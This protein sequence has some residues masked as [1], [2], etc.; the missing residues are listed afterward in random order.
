MTA[1][2]PALSTTETIFLALLS[3]GWVALFVYWTMRW[4]QGR[5]RI[6]PP[7]GIMI[8]FAL[9]EMLA[10]LF[11]WYSFLARERRRDRLRKK[12]AEFIALADRLHARAKGRN[13]IGAI[14]AG[15]RSKPGKFGVTSDI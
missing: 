6:T 3:I 15:S 4:R 8:P 2:Q 10:T 11:T 14:S 13:Q 9:W 1:M 5:A 7:F 12:V